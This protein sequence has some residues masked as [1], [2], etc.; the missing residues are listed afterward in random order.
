M[1]DQ[2]KVTTEDNMTIEQKLAFDAGFN[3]GIGY[4]KGYKDLEVAHLKNQNR[5]LIA[6]GAMTFIAAN[7]DSVNKVLN[8][9][10]DKAKDKIQS[11]KEKKNERN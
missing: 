10:C 5:F 6:F 4:M 8:A 11:I 2:F 7:Y 9:G 3:N 1:S